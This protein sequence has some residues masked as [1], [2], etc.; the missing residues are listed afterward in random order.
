MGQQA[1]L[2][3]V[4]AEK[5]G[6]AAGPGRRY[7][8]DAELPG[9]PSSAI[10]KYGYAVPSPRSRVSLIPKVGRSS[11]QGGVAEGRGGGVEKGAGREGGAFLLIEPLRPWIF[12]Y[13]RSSLRLN[14][15]KAGKVT[16]CFSFIIY[17][18]ICFSDRVSLYSS[19]P[20][21]LSTPPPTHRVLG[22]KTLFCF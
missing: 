20:L 2:G 17:L 11:S 22:L 9:Y 1:G 8:G 3:Q 16:F 15:I 19:D 10:A 14:R 4:T 5:T 7:R 12:F 18:S 21:E 6:D 13:L